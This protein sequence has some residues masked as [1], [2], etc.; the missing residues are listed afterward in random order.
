MNSVSPR[1]RSTDP[2]HRRTA[3]LLVLLIFFFVLIGMWTIRP[4]AVRA[5]VDRMES[6]LGRT[7]SSSSAVAAPSASRN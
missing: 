2:E 1:T 3:R 7:T 6:V 4:H 5:A